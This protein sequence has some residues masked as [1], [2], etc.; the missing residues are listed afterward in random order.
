MR[1]LKPN[2][3]PLT[4]GQFKPIPPTAWQENTPVGLINLPADENVVPY[5]QA[6][7]LDANV[8]LDIGG[9]FAL[10]WLL[11][12]GAGGASVTY[13]IDAGGLQQLCVPASQLRVSLVAE[14][15]GVQNTENPLTFVRP[16][17]VIEASAFFADGTTSTEPPSFTQY[18]S[19]GAGN[20]LFLPPPV[21][22]SNWRLMGDPT[23]GVGPFDATTEYK[24]LTWGAQ[25]VDQ[26]TGAQV[27]AIR[28]ADILFPSI[29]TKIQVA[30]NGATAITGWIEWGL[31]L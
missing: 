7:A 12:I 19:I 21:G 4:W 14:N 16:D 11:T 5:T 28:S 20:T 9:T 15:P 10:R 2:Q 22:A 18:F 30:N 27:Y 8:P 24:V 31:D 29:A 17:K 23:A 3:N 6:L 13:K 1:P 25:T 26:W